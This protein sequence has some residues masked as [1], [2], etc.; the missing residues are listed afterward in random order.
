MR[1]SNN[2]P[3]LVNWYVEQPFTQLLI[4]LSYLSAESVYL[5]SKQR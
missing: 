5:S 1:M 2:D 4:T 3:R